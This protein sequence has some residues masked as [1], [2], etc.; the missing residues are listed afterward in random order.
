MCALGLAVSALELWGLGAADNVGGSV[1]SSKHKT[2]RL[3]TTRVPASWNIFFVKYDAS[4][5]NVYS[6]PCPTGEMELPQLKR[7]PNT[8]SPQGDI[9]LEIFKIQ[10][11]AHARLNAKLEARH[12]RYLA[13]SKHV[14][15]GLCLGFESGHHTHRNS[16]LKASTPRRLS[17]RCPTLAGSTLKR[18]YIAGLADGSSIMDSTSFKKRLR[19]S[20]SHECMESEHESDTVQ[21][22]MHLFFQPTASRWMFMAIGMITP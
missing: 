2:H 14:C 22:H 8:V 7:G 10:D 17:R 9:N 19:G 5:A 15:E 6:P 18:T 20:C 3:E 1:A 4:L 21:N 16:Y 12:P 13:G 11:K